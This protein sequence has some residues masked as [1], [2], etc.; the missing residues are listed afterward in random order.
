VGFVVGLVPINTLINGWFRYTPA[1]N[2]IASEL[3]DSIR[4]AKAFILT[5][6]IKW[7]KR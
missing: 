2:G 5:K 1:K 7:R 3:Y 4:K 6:E